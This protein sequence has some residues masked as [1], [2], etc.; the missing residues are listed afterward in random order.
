MLG[1]RCTSSMASARHYGCFIKRDPQQRTARRVAQ[2]AEI[3]ESMLSSDISG[4]EISKLPTL[5][6]LLT[7]PSESDCAI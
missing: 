5:D 7:A 3:S 6:R 1:M 4:R 2:D